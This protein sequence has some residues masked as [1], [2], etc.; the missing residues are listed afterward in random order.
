M[1]YDKKKLADLCLIVN[2]GISPSYTEDRGIL[3]FNQRC[4]RDGRVTIGEARHTDP[5]KK[6]IPEDRYLINLDILVNSTGVGTLG[7]V[8]QIYGLKEKATIDSHVTLVRADAKKIDPTFLGYAIK[9]KQSDIENLAEGS[10]GQTE[11]SR[12]RLREISIPFPTLP[13]QHAIADVLSALDDKIELNRRMNQTLEQLAQVIFKHM[14]INNPER[15]NWEVKKLDA[16]C[17][18]EYGKALKA[19]NRNSGKN[20]VY[21]SNGC[22]G[23]HDEFLVKAPGIVIGRKGNPGIITFVHQN[24][25]PIDTT[26]YVVPKEKISLYWLYYALGSLN[27]PNLGTDSAVPGLNR[28]IAYLSALSLPSQKL[29]VEFESIVKPIFIKMHSNTEESRTLAE[30]RDTLLPKLMSEQVRVIESLK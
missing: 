22:V 24:F 7:R 4:I 13:E 28:N 16:I 30:L 23:Y 18:F 14:F 29:L 1:S 21:G 12:D 5:N 3:I 17:S 2:R 9:Y 8:S 27:L 6:H 19:S 26:F 15:K 10:T 25:F 11:L 20:P